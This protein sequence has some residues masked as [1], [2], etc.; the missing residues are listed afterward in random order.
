[1]AGVAGAPAAAAGAAVVV[2]VRGAPA[3]VTTAPIAREGAVDVAGG[4]AEM[5][6]AAAATGAGGVATGCGTTGAGAAGGTGTGTGTGMGTGT[7]TGTGT[8]GTVGTVTEGGAM[9]SARPG[10]AR[11]PAASSADVMIAPPSTCRRRLPLISVERSPGC[12]RYSERL[13]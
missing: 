12:G 6:G 13:H 7:G 10:V 2:V 3:W 4:V 1:V 8:A 5:P 9:P 11:S